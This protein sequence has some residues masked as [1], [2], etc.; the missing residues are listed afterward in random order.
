MLINFKSSEP[1]NEWEDKDNMADD[2]MK[3]DDFQ[4]NMGTGDREDQDFGQQSAGRS[5]QM[6]QQPGKHGQPGGQFSG[7]KGSQ[8]MEDDD[9]FGTGTTGHTG[10]QSRGGQNR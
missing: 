2:R 5:G 6:G 1:S 8:N 9:D 3:K 10:G 4:R 7:Q